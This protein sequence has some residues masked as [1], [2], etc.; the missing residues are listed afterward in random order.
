MKTT[1]MRLSRAE[2]MRRVREERGKMINTR[3]KLQ[4]KEDSAV[5]RTSNLVPREPRK[6]ALGRGRPC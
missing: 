6:L 3:R 2:S 4:F 1:P 5:Q